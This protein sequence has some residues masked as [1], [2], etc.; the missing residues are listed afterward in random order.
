MG[1]SEF[2]S[3]ALSVIDAKLAE[4]RKLSLAEAADLPGAFL[5]DIVVGDK[6]VQLTIFRQQGV[7]DFPDAVLVTVQLARAGLG[8]VINFQKERALVF[9]ANG[10][11]REA[12]EGELL[13]TGG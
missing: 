3:A 9:Q 11:I 4:L 8:G 7:P 2:E 10:E 6:E 1:R 12:T 13:A 5:E